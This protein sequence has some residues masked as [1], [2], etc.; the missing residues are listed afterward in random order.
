MGKGKRRNEIAKLDQKKGTREGVLTANM[1]YRHG[2]HQEALTDLGGSSLQSSQLT[3][4]M[5]K[6]ERS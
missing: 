4:V 1:H 2:G 5:G 3:N 6:D